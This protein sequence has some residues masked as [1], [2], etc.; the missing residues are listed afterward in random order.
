MRLSVGH[1]P[2]FSGVAV[3]EPN[4][5]RC[6]RSPRQPNFG[7]E[8]T[9]LPLS[10]L[11]KRLSTCR[12][13]VYDDLCNLALSTCVY[14][15]V[16]IS[17]SDSTAAQRGFQSSLCPSASRWPSGPNTSVSQTRNLSI[18]RGTI[19]VEMDPLNTT[20]SVITVLQLFSKVVQYIK[21][22]AGATKQRKGL[23]DELRQC[24][25]ILQYLKDEADDSEEGK[26]WSETIKALE[27]PGAPLHR[28]SVALQ[29]IGAKLQPKEG[30]RKALA[31]LEWPFNE[32][33]IKEIYATI[34]QEKSLLELALANNSRKLIQENKR[35]LDANKRQLTELIQ[36]IKTSSDENKGQIS[37]LK[38]DLRVVQSSQA[39]LHDSL[40]R[41]HH[42]QE[43]RDLLEE[44]S[45]ILNWLAP[46]DYSSQQSD[47]IHRRQPG[48][49]QW[50]LDSEKYQA[51][52]HAKGKTLFCPGIPGAGKTILTSIVVDDLSTRFSKDPTIG[53]AYI[54]CN[55][56]R[57]N[58]QKVESLLA[59]L[60]KQLAGRQA[61]L[62]ESVKALHAQY[63]DKR[64]QAS[65]D[66]VSKAFQSVIATHARVFVA[67]DAVDE[68]QASDRKKFLSELLDIQAKLGI[69]LLVTS[70]FIPEIVDRFGGA[71]T[72][73]IRAS[74]EDVERYIEGHLEELPA[75]VQRNRP[76]QREIKA[77]ILN[78][79]DGM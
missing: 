17:N 55:F 24:E 77:G 33:A 50:L 39:G 60:L 65:C 32:K 27:A 68:Y 5:P 79:A 58:E 62:P 40:D 41:L 52:L 51:W 71:V 66:A 6:C 48:T 21:S 61:T 26:A 28:L 56:R 22:A 47:F 46:I 64:T 15:S 7:R 34:E 18:V 67:I 54:Y 72:L 25:N 4:M 2:V 11:A 12:R 37:K 59:N 45:T 78:A 3:A 43:S 57:K 63:K 1:P 29:E 35:T 38:D 36:A 30:L 23:R 20:A 70:R 31:S 44:Q 49:G 42:R 14:K 74:S 53:F 10:F 19:V 75:F 69:N 13:I 76:L 16:D 73:E 8:S 9:P